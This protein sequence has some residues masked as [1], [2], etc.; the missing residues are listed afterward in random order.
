M[1]HGLSR[2]T[3]NIIILAC[4]VLIVWI[5]FADG[6]RENQPLEPLNLAPLPQ[7][8]WTH[9]N[10]L[11]GVSV[12]WQS[13]LSN[14]LIVIIKQEDQ[15]K[16]YELD[17]ID[18]ANGLKEEIEQRPKSAPAS[19]TLMGPLNDQEMAS[20]SAY[21]ISELTLLPLKQTDFDP[22]CQLDFAAGAYWWNMQMGKSLAAPA[23]INDSSLPSRAEWQ[24]F[25]V[26]ATK[27]IRRMLLNPDSAIDI[28]SELTY[29]QWPTGYLAKLYS[30]LG[31]AQKEAP[32]EYKACL[33]K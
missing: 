5:E 8:K 22:D 7:Q 4:L 30:G 24:E 21:L 3:L 17:A 32:L 14:R 10:S 11:E 27:N 18:W 25:R 6:N 26:Q 15:A 33:Q 19:L 13:L 12:Y 29:Y 23:E 16:R 9:W 28:K 31:K 1:F 2:W 20:A